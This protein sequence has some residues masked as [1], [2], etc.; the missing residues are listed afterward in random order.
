MVD[1]LIL[2]T[3]ETHREIMVAVQEHRNAK[4]EQIREYIAIHEEIQRQRDERS[5]RASV[6]PQSEP[7]LQNLPDVN[8]S[9]RSYP[10]LPPYRQ[11]KN[12]NDGVIQGESPSD[13]NIHESCNE[14]SDTNKV[15]NISIIIDVGFKLA[16]IALSASAIASNQWLGSMLKEKTCNYGQP[17]WS[18]VIPQRPRTPSRHPFLYMDDQSQSQVSSAT[19]AAPKAENSSPPHAVTQPG[20]ACSFDYRSGREVEEEEEISSRYKDEMTNSDD[21]KKT[22]KRNPSRS[23]LHFSCRVSG[24]PAKL[25]H[26]S[27]LRRH[28]RKE[29][30]HTSKRQPDIPCTVAGCPEMFLSK[31]DLK[32]HLESE[33]PNE[34][35]P[36]FKRIN[37]LAHDNSKSPQKYGNSTIDRG[38]SNSKAWRLSS[39]LCSY[40]DGIYDGTGPEGTIHDGSRRKTPRGMSKLSDTDGAKRL[41]AGTPSLAQNLIEK[42]IAMN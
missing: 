30:P 33:H 29:H 3:H 6:M 16:F 17:N 1:S 18:V 14:P 34:P 4:T 42:P 28:L 15:P 11:H 10:M 12:E 22:Q 39:K 31:I 5:H 7:A 25:F 21:S 38:G 36:H 35:K 27:D 13:D 2:L 8:P 24:C 20:P 23:H 41:C 9:D 26:E 37:R 32:D 40:G 19:L